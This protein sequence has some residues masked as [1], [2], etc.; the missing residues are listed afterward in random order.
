MLSVVA[1]RGSAR[2]IAGRP[3]VKISKDDHRPWLEKW[4][5][6]LHH[7]AR[8]RRYY[9]SEVPD[10]SNLDVEAWATGF[11]VECNHLV[12]W[13]CHDISS[14]GGVT[15]RQIRDFASDSEALRRC[16]A[17]CN[18]HKHHTRNTMKPTA[19]IGDV[20]Q[21]RGRWQV[22]VELDWLSRPGGPTVDAL[23]LADQ[24][25]AEWQRFLELHGITNPIRADR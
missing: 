22:T 20:E 12:D 6:V 17:I 1:G 2:L 5:F 15:K 14:L 25:V 21:S 9:E 24:C 19:R 4:R 18:T 11:F 13:L 23:D 8:L 10:T 3:G 7:L 16:D